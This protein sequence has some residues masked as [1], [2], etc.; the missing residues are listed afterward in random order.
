[1]K[2]KLGV[3]DP[4]VYGNP[5]ADMRHGIDLPGPL[6]YASKRKSRRNRL[7]TDVPSDIGIW[8]RRCTHTRRRIGHVRNHAGMS[9][10]G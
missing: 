5:W 6:K 4:V 10:G 7:I 2:L 1:M 9:S 8:S 3:L